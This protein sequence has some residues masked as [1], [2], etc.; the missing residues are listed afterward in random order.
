VVNLEQLRKQAKELVRAARA[1]DESALARLGGHEPILA[2]AQLALARERGYASW[3]ALVAAVDTDAAAFVVAATS[4]RQVRAEA[5]L[6]ARPE[7]ER[8]PWARLVL[9]R[10]WKGDSNE[11]GG[12]RGWAPLLYVCHSCFAS[13]ALA[14][15]LLARGADPNVY[16]VNEY[17]RMSAL[18]GAAGVN[19]NPE[20][21]RV[22]LEAGA[23][24]DDGESLYHAT[25][26]ESS[27]C[28]RLLLEHGATT[29]GTNALPHALDYD[30]I[31]HV[32]L[33]LDAGADPN[34]G[35]TL[36][37]AVRRGRGPEFL[38]LLVQRGAKLDR[39]GG[40]WSRLDKPGRT[41]YQHAVRRGRADQASAL[42]ELGASTEV[43]AVDEALGAVAR[44][45]RPSGR[46]PEELDDDA[47][48]VLVLAAL[49]GPLDVVLDLVGPN[50]RGCV[51]G[52]P[53]GTLLH[54]AAWVGNPGLVRAL[55]ARGADPNERAD[56]DF[57]TPL[58]WAALASC[59]HELAERDY[60]A[61]AEMLV[62][63]GNTIES[64]FLDVADGPLY[65]WLDERVLREEASHTR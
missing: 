28:L 46:L 39:P 1:G 49:S 13:T 61:V 14:R 62:E 31:E 30:R 15:E 7:I 23:S 37:H 5:M 32:R 56:A 16:F 36:V 58:G 27:E 45:E 40:E 41:A 44:G 6:A 34:E 48:E 4:N 59:Y 33:L 22:L 3:A 26:A 54:H 12:P 9:G 52:S 50:F 63:A 35:A 8:D 25:E 10:E 47:R 11:K 20:L 17:G 55:L 21:T 51:G 42:A 38:R 60:V 29:S 65:D 64:R 24:P 2:R 19:H 43:H 57:D 18:Y 53:P